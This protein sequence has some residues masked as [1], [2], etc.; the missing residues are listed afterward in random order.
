MVILRPW[1][2]R[3]RPLHFWSFVKYRH[4]VPLRR[5]CGELRRMLYWNGCFTL[6]APGTVMLCTSDEPFLVSCAPSRPSCKLMLVWY[7]TC[8]STHCKQINTQMLTLACVCKVNRKGLPK[9]YYVDRTNHCYAKMVLVAGTL[10]TVRWVSSTRAF[11]TSAHTGRRPDIIC[12][13]QT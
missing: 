4:C 8:V 11:V 7:R 2:I 13:C 10:Q 6:Q 1:R 3:P 5:S 9:R 12:G